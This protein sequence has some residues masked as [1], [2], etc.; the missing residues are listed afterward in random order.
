MA[1]ATTTVAT[2]LMDQQAI[3]GFNRGPVISIFT[4]PAS[5]LSTLTLRSSMYFGHQFGDYY[6]TACFP[7]STL[8]LGVS[9]WDL[10]YCEYCDLLNQLPL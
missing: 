1:A 10:Y 3:A 7:S 5:C 4:P 2:V 8:N 6:D 9:A